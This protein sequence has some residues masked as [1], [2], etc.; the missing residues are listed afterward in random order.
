MQWQAPNAQMTAPES[1]THQEQTKTPNQQR[2]A[3]ALGLDMGTEKLGLDFLLDS[4]QRRLITSSTPTNGNSVRHD[5]P[6]QSSPMHQRHNSH[7]SNGRQTEFPL[8]NVG[9]AEREAHSAPIRNCSPTNPLDHVLLACIHEG[10][11]Q[12]QEGIP[13]SKIVGPSY[14]C[15]SSFLNHSKAANPH[16]FS[17][18]FTEIL[19]IYPNISTVPEK[20]AAL[21]IM[22]LLMRWQISSTQENYDRLPDWMT[23]RPSQLFT[24]HPAWIDHLPW[25]RMREK[26]VRE[27]PHYQF[28]HFFIHFTTSLSL[29]WPYEDSDTILNVGAGG[30]DATGDELTINPVFERHLMRLENWS[31]GPAFATAFPGLRDTYRLKGAEER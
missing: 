31:L 4:A 7:G 27:Y 16:P 17:K 10:Q 8:R 5:S 2:H 3:L 21:H 25:P 13:I 18:V 26:L 28:D 12:A 9:F 19:G 23:P 30:I 6:D 22:F 15:V 11:Q 20:L 14:P 24:A 29:N 1:G